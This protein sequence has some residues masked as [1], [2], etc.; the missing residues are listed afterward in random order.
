MTLKVGFLTTM[1]V[2]VGDDFIREGVRAVLDRIGAPYSPLYVNK[3][4]P[5]SVSE[6][7]EDETELVAD[8]YWDAD[9]FIQSGAPVYWR[10]GGGQH[11][12]LTA[13]W[14]G[15][16]WR[17]RALNRERR[18]GPAFLNLGAGSAMFWNDDGS[19]YA[20]DPGCAA[21][22]RAA[23]ERSALTTVRD[24]LAGSILTKLGVAHR[25]IACPAF[26]AA[27]RHPAGPADPRLIAVNLMPRGG[28]FDLDPAFEPAPWRERS[29]RLVRLLRATGRLVFVCHDE[30]ELRF[31]ETLAAPGERLYLAETWQGC[32]SL[33]SAAAAVV[34]NRV[35]GAVCAAGYGVPS[36]VIGK[37]TRARIGEFIG[38]PVLRSATLDPD[39]AAALVAGYLASRHDESERLLTLRERTLRE[40]R[41]L[42]APIVGAIR[43]KAAP[44]SRP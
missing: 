12:S 19:D 25:Q 39:A 29:A 20:A 11:S 43:P 2:N 7:R 44:G 35:H 10:H 13:E 36:V 16:F 33:Y 15:W 24:P 18:D 41:E 26:L 31:A 17:D 14:H 38:L 30:Q 6:P 40:H 22:A 23:G 34:A 9:L 1:G 37:D 4:D 32:M 8:K 28:H 21:F 42:L 27:A 3:H 5:A